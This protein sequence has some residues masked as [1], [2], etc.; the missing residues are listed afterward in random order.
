MKYLIKNKKQTFNIILSI[1]LAGTLLLSIGILFSSFRNYLIYKIDKY[2]V[3]ITGEINYKKGIK[4][5][6]LKNNEY[7]IIYKNI[8]KT[9]ENTKE[10]CKKNTCTNITYNKKLLALY[11]L[12]EDETMD[13]IKQLLLILVFIFAL[14]SFFIIYN[15]FD[16]YKKKKDIAL[17]K[18]AGLTNKDI[19][20]IFIKE[21]FKIGLIGIIISF[22]T[23]LILNIIIIKII[24][25]SLYEVLNGKLKLSIY[26]PFINVSLIFLIIVIVI[27]FLLPL[28]KIKKYKV[29]DLFHEEIEDDRVDVTF[30]NFT[31][32]Y[33]FINYFRSRK[34]YKGL[35]IC[36][37]TLML[38]INIFIT[39]MNYTLKVIDEYVIIPNYDLAL[40]SNS[41]INELINKLNPSKKIIFKT[42]TKSVTLNE[43]N[44]IT[45]D[46]VY[47]DVMVTNLKGNT[48][49]NKVYEI[50]E[51]NNKMLKKEYKPFKN[52]NEITI[53]E[54]IKVNLTDKIPFGFDNL[55]SSNTLILNLN[56]D[57]FNKVCPLYEYKAF[58]N[59]D[60]KGLDNIIKKYALKNNQDISYIN[61]KKGIELTNNFLLLLKLFMY[62]CLTIITITTLLTI[63]NIISASIDFRKKEFSTLKCIGLT[64]LKI[65][66][67]L[68][69]ESLIISLKGTLYVFPFILIIDKNLYINI[70]KYFNIKTNI[71]D[72]KL[73]I[74]SFIIIFFLIFISNTISH[75]SLY[76]KSLIYN[77]KNG[78]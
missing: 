19:Y 16:I 26:V 59:T 25:Q 8:H 77:I 7:E 68:L 66:L 32:K 2:H 60:K 58:I 5:I 75:K 12:G 38:L 48:I 10:I 67:C 54:T 21:G 17:L 14:S 3:K 27:S 41:D 9:Y 53:N 50:T 70:L 78:Y 74:L 52:L 49:I 65:N 37:F 47:K 22:I 39:F 13:L 51:D 76:K 28:L 72:Y 15:V 24:N 55:L 6:K 4:S 64:N 73:F 29:I 57:E 33:A 42:C 18:S 40:T 44:L 31:L 36:V 46:S 43:E 71:F 45:D 62:L 11:G 35:I 69:F 34:K 61:V 1:V 20:I 63:F 23:S 56:D 30:K